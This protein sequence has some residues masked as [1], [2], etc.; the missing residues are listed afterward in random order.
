MAYAEG[1]RTKD[2]LTLANGHATMGSMEAD[3]RKVGTMAR[4]VPC[5]HGQDEHET[6]AERAA[7]ASKGW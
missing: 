1:P 3:G 4:Q 5:G 6:E 2:L 7:C